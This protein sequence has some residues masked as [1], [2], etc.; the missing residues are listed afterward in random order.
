MNSRKNNNLWDRMPKE[1]EQYFEAFNVFKD[2]GVNRTIGKVANTLGKS[3]SHCYNMH[4]KWNWAER[5]KAWDDEVQKIKN[6]A[7][8]KSVQQMCKRH[9]DIAMAFQNPL[10]AIVK[11][12][13]RRIENKELESLSIDKFLA[14]YMKATQLLDSVTGVERKARGEATEITKTDI[15]SGGDKVHVVLPS[16]NEPTAENQPFEYYEEIDDEELIEDN[17]N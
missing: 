1:C 6:N 13:G 4:Q 12:A 2:L 3:M 11:E 7:Q 15:T 9:A 10:V 8:L 5:A 17:E 14:A 16:L